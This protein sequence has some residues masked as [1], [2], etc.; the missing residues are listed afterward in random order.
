MRKIDML[1][2]PHAL[3]IVFKFMREK[4]GRS[5]RGFK[6]QEPFKA[7]I[8]TMLSLRARGA[9]VERVETTLFAEASTPQQIL[10]MPV[11]TLVGLL[12]PLGHTS[13]RAQFVR[14]TCEQLIARFNGQ[15]PNN[16]DDL[17]SL[18]GVGRKTAN[19]T[20]D[21]GFGQTTMTVDTHVHRIMNIWG[22]VNT[23][24]ANETEMVLR[25]KLP[26][27]YWKSFNPLLVEFGNLVCWPA[28]PKCQSCPLEQICPKL[29]LSASHKLN[30]DGSST[31]KASLR[32]RKPA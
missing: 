4:T 29:G 2:A 22:Y 32:P 7:L 12:R 6:R 16:M 5:Y 21:S 26:R 30:R 17:L 24:N 20:L 9:T 18:P 31:L 23:K 13:R 28:S 1:N 25:D 15:V 14:A 3:D 11:E 8:G 10:D 27:K 19:L